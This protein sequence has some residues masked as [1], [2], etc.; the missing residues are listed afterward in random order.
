MDFEVI[1]FKAD[2]LAVSAEPF[3]N[4]YVGN[5]EVGGFKC[6]VTR[7]VAGYTHSIALVLLLGLPVCIVDN[8]KENTTSS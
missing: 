7:G 5:A 2:K 8:V 3:S 4:R 6:R 1:A